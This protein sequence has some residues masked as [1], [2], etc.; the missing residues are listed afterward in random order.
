MVM[1]SFFRP[2]LP[3]TKADREWFAANVTSWTPLHRMLPRLTER[4]LLVVVLLE[5]EGNK[6]PEII[7]RSLRRFNRVR[8]ARELK[9]LWTVAPRAG[10]R[11]RELA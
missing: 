2:A 5:I 1:P 7:G 6:R 4:Q 3:I 10:M 8:M 11:G 9:E